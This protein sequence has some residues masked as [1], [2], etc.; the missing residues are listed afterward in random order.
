MNLSKSLFSISLLSSIT[1][2]TGVEQSIADTLV[3]NGSLSCNNISTLKWENDQVII[4]CED[5]HIDPPQVSP[6][7]VTPPIVEPPS[8]GDEPNNETPDPILDSSCGNPEPDVQIESFSGDGVDKEF[9]V[10]NETVLSVP[11]NSSD[12]GSVRR[13]ALIEPA[14]GEH[15]QKTAIISKCP[16][17]F[18][19]EEYDYTNSVDICV[20]T[21]LELSF[22]TISGN[23]RSDYPLSNY[24]CVLSPNE[25]YYINVFQR[26]AGRRPPFKANG[27]N[28][29]RT[30]QCGVRVI[31]R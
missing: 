22:N 10:E 27:K 3:L 1:L 24:R 8:I 29:C 30:N 31:I 23:N 12:I 5:T 20:V 14:R 21:G 6:P 15:F 16:G 2:F 4:N 13:I 17:V 28:T 9:T 11:F 7:V 18:N 26:D 19:P 25:Q